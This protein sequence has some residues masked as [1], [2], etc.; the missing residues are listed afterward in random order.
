MDGDKIVGLWMSVFEVFLWFSISVFE[1]FYCGFGYKCMVLCDFYE[2]CWQIGD[3]WANDDGLSSSWLMVLF[4]YSLVSL[5]LWCLWYFYLFSNGTVS[6]GMSLRHP[7]VTLALLSTFDLYM[8]PS[9]PIMV[10][11]YM[12]SILKI[13]IFI[14]WG[15]TLYV[16]SSWGH[17]FFYVIQFSWNTIYECTWF[18]LMNSKEMGWCYLIDPSRLTKE[19]NVSWLFV[20]FP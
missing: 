8:V 4:S 15:R 7:Y 16:V 1:I 18:H 10:V 11:V 12:F 13:Y 6:A 19:I 20:F 5:L 9:R 3:C 14:T 2:F 17:Q